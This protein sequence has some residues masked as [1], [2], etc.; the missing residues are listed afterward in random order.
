MLVQTG[1]Y[2]DYS[3]EGMLDDLD[4]HNNYLVEVLSPQLGIDTNS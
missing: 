4:M 3:L 2:V 1:I